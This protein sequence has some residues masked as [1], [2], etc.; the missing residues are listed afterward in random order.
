MQVKNIT[1]AP[2]CTVFDVLVHRLF[3]KMFNYIGYRASNSE[4]RVNDFLKKKKNIRKLS[5]AISEYYH[6]TYF[7][8]T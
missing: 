7:I 3:H 1:T 2:G 4:M 8:S 5:W 6:R